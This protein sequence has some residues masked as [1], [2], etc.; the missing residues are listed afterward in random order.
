MPRNVF[1]TL[2]LKCVPYEAE[3]RPHTLSRLYSSHKTF[4]WARAAQWPLPAERAGH[5]EALASTIR[6]AY[7]TD[8]LEVNNTVWQSY[9]T[10]PLYKDSFGISSS[11]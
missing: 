5:V 4:R 8:C 10:F 2:N 3:G 1:K 7:G 11:V 6:A 9:L